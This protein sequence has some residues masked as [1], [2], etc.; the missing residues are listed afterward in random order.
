MTEFHKFMSSIESK[1][2]A[3]KKQSRIQY[4]KLLKLTEKPIQETSEK[5]II[6]LLDDTLF[7]Y[8]RKDKTLKG[9]LK[10]LVML[11]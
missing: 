5:K 9:A 1:S 7:K 11:K 6:E 10:M 4:N 2:D 3:T 8:K